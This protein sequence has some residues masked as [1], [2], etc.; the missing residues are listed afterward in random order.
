MSN[1]PGEAVVHRP[2][3]GA[4]PRSSPAATASTSRQ[5]RRSNDEKCAG[6]CSNLTGRFPVKIAYEKEADALY[7]RL[8]D[9][10]FECWTVRLSDDVALD[11]SAGE[12]LVGIEILGASRLF[13]TLESPTISNI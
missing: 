7:I 12:R 10:R 4:K 3:A 8:L 11:F 9:G 2:S 1:W 13:D 5:L 6:I